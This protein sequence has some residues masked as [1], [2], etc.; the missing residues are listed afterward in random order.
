METMQTYCFDAKNRKFSFFRRDKASRKV[1]V[2]F[3]LGCEEE[4]VDICTAD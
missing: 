1:F 2:T 3:A 4:N